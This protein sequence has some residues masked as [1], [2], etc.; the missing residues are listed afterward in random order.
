MTCFS[1]AASLVSAKMSEPYDYKKKKK[2]IPAH[3]LLG[4]NDVRKW[5]TLILLDLK[6]RVCQY[7]S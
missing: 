6:L 4:L 7:G 5:S 2:K 1:K 3:F